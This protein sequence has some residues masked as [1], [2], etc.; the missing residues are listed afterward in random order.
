MSLYFIIY[1]IIQSCFLSK[2]FDLI[3]NEEN[4][5][6]KNQFGKI[7][8]WKRARARTRVNTNIKT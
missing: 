6:Q 7:K 4:E 3:L 1:D 5:Q 8:K 2:N